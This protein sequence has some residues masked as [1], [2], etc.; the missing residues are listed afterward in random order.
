VGGIKAFKD[1]NPTLPTY[2]IYQAVQHIVRSILRGK[3]TIR[4]QLKLP[5]LGVLN[6]EMTIKDNVLKLRMLTENTSVKE[7]LLSNV[8]KLREILAQ[9]GIKL[10]R[11]DIQTYIKDSV[12]LRQSRVKSDH[13]VDLIA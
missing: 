1:Q 9:K 7:L 11:V 10:E 12:P 5:D 13:V 3:R 2:L 6:L 8:H 4:L